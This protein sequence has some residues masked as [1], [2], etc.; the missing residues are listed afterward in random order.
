MV[1]GAKEETITATQARASLGDILARARYGGH[2]FVI[3]Q[4]GDPAAVVMGYEDYRELMTLLED[5]EDV[6]DMLESE[7]EPTRPLHEY[8]AERE[9]PHA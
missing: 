9:Q 7:G 1:T 3:Q 6:R 8:L 2:R 4:H 5:L